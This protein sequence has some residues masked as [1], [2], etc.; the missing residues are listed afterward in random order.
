MLLLFLLLIG[1]RAH[2]QRTLYSTGFEFEEDYLPELTLTGQNGWV[3]YGADGI[4][5]NFFAGFG[6]QAYVG[7]APPPGE[8]NDF[9]GVLRPLN[10]TPSGTSQ[11]VKFSVLMQIFD[12][13]STNG[14]WDDFRWSVY[15]T[16]GN[17]F[18]SVD[19]DNASLL[20]SYVLDDGKGFI[21]ANAKFDTQGSYEL[22]ME[23]NFAR[24]LW[25]ATLNDVVIV[26]A[27]PITTV[28][29]P[30]N[31]GDID[32]VWA[33]RDPVRPGDNFMAFDNYSVTVEASPSIQ[34]RL[35]AFGISAAGSFQA[36]FYGEPGLVYRIESSADFIHWEPLLTF[37]APTGGT[38]D[39]Q[40]PSASRS[41][42]KS[43]RA[44]QGQGP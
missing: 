38:L 23:M 32:A 17:R 22:T 28:G 14:P 8:T 3:G 44:R 16:N 6:Q 9:Y 20:V 11:M 40:D 7:Y 34:P 5:T 24:N 21:P 42:Q 39:F 26:N 12:S 18:F 29:S 43:Y 37:T 35:E 31:L 15:N 19:F 36:R 41:A 25:S 1:V 2:G 10:F 27:Q 33:V 13:T 4:V 30:L